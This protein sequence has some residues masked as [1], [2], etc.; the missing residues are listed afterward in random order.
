MAIVAHK[1]TGEI[2][3]DTGNRIHKQRY[4]TNYFGGK[5]VTTVTSHFKDGWLSGTTT[6][7]RNIPIMQMVFLFLLFAA[8]V[9][10]LRGGQ[11]KTFYSFLQLLGRVKAVDISFLVNWTPSFRAWVD[12]W[13]SAASSIPVI[14][15]FA[16][17]LGSLVSA[18]VGVIE[19]G[20]FLFEGLTALISFLTQFITWVF[21]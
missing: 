19:F 9:I 6:R 16:A 12:T 15:E 7:T 4:S 14:G 17:W 5:R 8:C 11:P 21:A 3:G 13:V 20:T 10:F 2:L 18:A 1:K